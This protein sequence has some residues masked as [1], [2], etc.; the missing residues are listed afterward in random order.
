MR[1][2]P[3]IVVGDSLL[4]V[5]LDGTVG[6]LAPDAPV[7]VV[8]CHRERHRAGG[9]G[10]AAVLAAN[11]AGPGV[12]LI[13]ATGSDRHGARLREILSRDVDVLAVPLRG[14]TPCKIRVQ[15]AGQPMLRLDVGSGIV[16]PGPLDPAIGRA[17]AGAGAVLVSDYGRGMTAHPGLRA[18][19]TRLR[20]DIPVVWDPH[21]RGAR[22]VPGVRL[23]TPNAAEARSLAA[24]S[25]SQARRRTCP[26][27]GVP[28][29]AISQVAQAAADA[30]TLVERWGTT[31]VS[32]TM[33]EHGALLSVGDVNPFMA[34][35][36]EVGPVSGASTCGAG[37]CF[38]A[39]AARVLRDGGVLTE[40]VVD[41]VRAAAEFVAQGGAQGAVASLTVPPTPDGADAGGRVR[42][43]SAWDVIATVRGRGGKVVATGGCFDLLHAGH[44]NLLRDARRLG[45]CLVVCLNSDASVRDLKGP[46]R[47]LVPAKDRARVLTALECVDAVLTFPQA[48]PA[49][50][51]GR[52]RPDIWVKGGDYAGTDLAEA[53][54]VSRHGGQVVLL[55]YLDGVSTSRIVA[56]ARQVTVPADRLS[57]SQQ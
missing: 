30:A 9:A 43:R 52:L 14:G 36:T 25:P 23:A 35:A 40:A 32:V 46:G 8:D 15:A 39:T 50:L 7:P 38:A 22:P 42:E 4:D 54:V 27:L 18:L 28:S 33:G 3:L 24:A 57:G 47:P 44:V 51:L 1:G 17:L 45:D 20:P 19:L 2:G 53:D 56:A 48:T 6:R 34:L 11:Q 16:E 49:V 5:D 21:P 31:A 55:P 26:A 13:T 41:A 10:L 37:D 12:V 29:R